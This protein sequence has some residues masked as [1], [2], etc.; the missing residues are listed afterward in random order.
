MEF[1]SPLLIGDLIRRNALAVPGR[2]AAS[3]GDR[4]LSHAELDAAANRVGWALRELGLGCGDRLVAWADTS[5]EQLVLFAGAS[6]LGA[7]FAPIDARLGAKEAVAVASIA[8]PR[9]LVADAARA[10][11][12]RG[13]AAELGIDAA[14]LGRLDG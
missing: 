11:A 7:V 10:P 3:L 9:L 8:R 5:L 4:V 13:V 14:E 6:K 1:A 2:A 12:S